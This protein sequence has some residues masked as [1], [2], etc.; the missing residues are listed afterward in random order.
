MHLDYI[1]L[2]KRIREE[3]LKL[4]LTQEKLAEDVELSTA[5]IGQIERGERHITLENLI[6]IVNR[7]NITVD[8]ILMDSVNMDNGSLPSLWIQ[9]MN[10]RTEIEKSM[11]VNTVKLIFGYLDHNSK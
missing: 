11:A 8:Y 2:G 3:R 1:A 5:Y 9:L 10:G 4:N 7:L 6:L